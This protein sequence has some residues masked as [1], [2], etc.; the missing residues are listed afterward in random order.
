MFKDISF[1][2]QLGIIF[3]LGMLLL[4]LISSVVLSEFTSREVRER[5]IDEGIKLTETFAE[6]S[7]LALLYSSEDSAAEAATVIKS[8]PD[9]D[10]VAI[11][12][13]TGRTLYSDLPREDLAVKPADSLDLSTESDTSWMFSSPVLSGGDSIAQ[14]PFDNTA[15]A[16]E[17]IG[18][19]RVLMSKKTLNQMESDIFRYNLLVS[20]GL[21]SILLL[22]LLTITNRLTRPLQNLARTMRRAEQGESSIR[23]ELRG[24]SDIRDMESAFNTMM[25]VLDG[26]EQALKTARDQALD[27]ARAK[28]E[29]AANVSHELRTP[30]NGVLGMLDLLSDMRLAAKQ[31]EFVGVARNSAESLLTLIDDLLNFSKNDAGK[32]ELSLREFDLCECLEQIIVLLGSQAQRK[33]IDFAYVSTP[34]IPQYLTGDSDRIRQ[35]LVNLAGNAIKFTDSGSVGIEVSLIEMSD[36]KANLRFEVWDTGLGI[37]LEQQSRIFEVFSQADESTTRKF[38][39]TGLGLSISRQLVELM[40]GNMGVDS[41]LGRGSRFWFTLPLLRQ[42]DNSK[43][44]NIACIKHIDGR[45]LVV[46]NNTLVQRSVGCLLERHGLNW[47]AASCY[48]T[49]RKKLLANNADQPFTLV[50]LDQMLDV[51]RGSELIRYMHTVPE[52]RGISTIAVQPQGAEADAVCEK[53]ASAILS[54][55]VLHKHLVDCINDLHDS[56][57]SHASLPAVTEPGNIMFR[58]AVF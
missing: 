54:K 57:L 50:I 47:E 38:G 48:E 34:D 26:R 7:T 11:V 49:A 27:S 45:V 40:G 6:Q 12:D 15:T 44:S 17:L 9:I 22:A 58:A 32:T 21:A 42:S 36:D 51:D 43:P 16:P 28:G 35:V 23:A 20:L 13:S 19:V 29:F 8:F 4:A 30:M 52:L 10:A 41:E 46:D 1:R 31:Q 18:H 33:K 53:Y 14:T 55:P 39:G 25:N 24:T 2:N 56:V 37:T 5:L 3:S